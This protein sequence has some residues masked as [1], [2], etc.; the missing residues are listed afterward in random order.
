MTLFLHRPTLANAEKNLGT[1]HPSTARRVYRGYSSLFVEAVLSS[2]SPRL[3]PYR[4]AMSTPKG[5]MIT[6]MK[7]VQLW[8]FL[9]LLSPALCTRRVI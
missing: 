8:M 3:C 7:A 1:M 9:E 5:V 2:W 6:P 4:T